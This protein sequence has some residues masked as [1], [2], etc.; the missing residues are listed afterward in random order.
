[1]LLFGETYRIVA[2]RENW[3]H[4]I[5][6]HDQYE[7]WIAAR[8]PFYLDEEGK[9]NV[10]KWVSC[11]ADDYWEDV[12][13]KTYLNPGSLLLQEEEMGAL[14]RNGRFFGKKLQAGKGRMRLEEFASLF[15][16]TPYLWG[17]RS[18]MGIDCSG[19][20]QIFM[21]LQGIAM[22]RDAYQ[23]AEVGKEVGS[24]NE[25]ISGDLLF[26]SE[27]GNRITHIGLLYEE[28]KILHASE[29]VRIDPINENGIYNSELEQY[30]LKPCLIKRVLPTESN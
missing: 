5:S 24:L 2:T 4:I 14:S 26:F 6:I 29:R 18:R 11:G 7:G 9:S 12:G 8:K 15:L 17:G 1:M 3:H 27:S 19:L 10:P 22:P 30:T 13:G 21:R 23:Q 20:T 16:N 25:A 28:G